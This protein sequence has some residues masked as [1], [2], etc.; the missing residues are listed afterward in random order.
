MRCSSSFICMDTSSADRRLLCRAMFCSCRAFSFSASTVPA[1]SESSAL[2]DNCRPATKSRK[3]FSTATRLASL[4]SSWHSIDL[5]SE[6]CD[7]SCPLRPALVP[8]LIACLSSDASPCKCM[9]CWLSSE[10]SKSTLDKRSSRRSL[11]A[12]TSWS[13]PSDSLMVAA[14]SPVVRLTDLSSVSSA[15]ARRSMA[16]NFSRSWVRTESSRRC[17]WVCAVRVSW[18]CRD[19]ASDCA[20]WARC[21]LRSSSTRI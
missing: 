19:S 1:A 14:A 5:E 6:E 21:T 2:L 8:R 16:K 11:S 10:R 3:S 7:V 4:F 13:S 12:R 20:V 18:W 9:I 17:W 15:T